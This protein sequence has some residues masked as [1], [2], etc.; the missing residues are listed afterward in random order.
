MTDLQILPTSALE[1]KSQ[2]STVHERVI[3]RDRQRKRR[4]RGYKRYLKI[5]LEK[6]ELHTN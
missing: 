1:L 5:L 3:M 4:G 2:T 6:E